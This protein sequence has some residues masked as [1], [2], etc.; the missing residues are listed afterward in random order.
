[1]RLPDTSNWMLLSWGTGVTVAVDPASVKTD[2]NRRHFRAQLGRVGS[3]RIVLVDA[4]AD[5]DALTVEFKAGYKFENKD[6]VGVGPV[7]PPEPR[8]SQTKDKGVPE[9]V[10]YVCK[11]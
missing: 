5:C 3:P 4:V 11:Y 9:V 1:M 6:A 7:D 10:A 2:E 8:V